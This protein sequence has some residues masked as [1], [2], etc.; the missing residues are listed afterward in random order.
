VRLDRAGFAAHRAS[1]ELR[2]A[3]ARIAGEAR[4]LRRLYALWA[5]AR[6]LAV[7]ARASTC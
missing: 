2:E 5:E 7:T 1:Q 3:L 4:L 6:G